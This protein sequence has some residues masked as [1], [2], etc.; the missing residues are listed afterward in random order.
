MVTE[1]NGQLKKTQN[2][3]DSPIQNE[4]EYEYSKSFNVHIVFEMIQFIIKFPATITG[5]LLTVYWLS[6]VTSVRRFDWAVQFRL[7]GLPCWRN[8]YFSLLPCFTLR[9]LYYFF[10][11]CDT[12][13]TWY[14]FKQRKNIREMHFYLFKPFSDIVYTALTVSDFEGQYCS[15]DSLLNFC[16]GYTYSVGYN[17]CR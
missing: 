16:I 14:L 5:G 4:M 6:D 17:I 9:F 12:C 10:F 11:V 13:I 2:A 7:V 8:A 15:T 3:K 1:R